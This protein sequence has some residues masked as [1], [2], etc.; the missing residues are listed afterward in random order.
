LTT[1]LKNYIAVT[2]GYWAFTITD[3]AIRMLVVL[4][5]HQ[6]GYSPLEIALVFL[7][8]EVFGVVTN[9]LGGWIGTLI[10]LNRI[11]QWGMALQVVALLLL[12]VPHDWL[13]VFYVMAVQAL[14][15][16]AKDLNKMSAKTTVKRLVPAD[17]NAQLLRWTS[18]LTGSKNTLKGVGFFVGALLLAT[19]GF[20]GA[21]F[22]LALPLALVLIFLLWFLPAQL[23]KSTSKT[24]FRQLF[25]R[26][27]AI[28]RLSLA[29]FFLFGARDVWFVVALPVFLASQGWATERTGAFLAFW[30]IGYGIIQASAPAV[31]K[32]RGKIP[33]GRSAI[34]YA[35]VLAL[36]PAL[37]VLLL[38]NGWQPV[39]VVTTGVLLFGV[40]FALNSALHSYLI[41]FYA[42]HDKTALDVGFYYMSNAMGRLCGTV[43]SGWIFQSYGIT[44]CLVCSAI[45]VLFAASA[46]RALS[47]YDNT[48]Q[49]T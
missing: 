46:S 35:I 29:R 14:S 10:G 33:G 7:F 32:R 38:V 16:I 34:G 17:A 42:D 13:S 43:L 5:F 23:G 24:P 44:A 3:G 26:K 21:L 12:A 18:V 47:Q 37:M 25:S 8:Y 41:L 22:T 31:L 11:M 9:L 6:L 39:R 4:Y 20:R 15:G 36:V 45:M 1:S 19:L 28:N 2:F 49:A 40:V 48:L 27:P 30:I